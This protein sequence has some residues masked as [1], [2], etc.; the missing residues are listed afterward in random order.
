MARATRVC[1][2]LK[3]DTSERTDKSTGHRAHLRPLS[4]P[5]SS[6]S[7][8]KPN[9]NPTSCREGRRNMAGS[10]RPVKCRADKWELMCL[11]WP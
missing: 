7:C 9:K 4:R 2:L 6:L 11:S 5:P 10:L 1:D 8:W 3:P